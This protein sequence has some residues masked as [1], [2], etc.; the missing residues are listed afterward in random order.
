M[1]IVWTHLNILATKPM[2]VHVEGIAPCAHNPLIQI[3]FKLHSVIGVQVIALSVRYQALSKNAVH[4]SRAQIIAEVWQVQL[5]C[6]VLGNPL[7]Q[8]EWK[9]LQSGMVP[10]V[11]TLE[12]LF[13]SVDAP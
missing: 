2:L 3:L 7:R 9:E 12:C 10:L 8:L 6:H 11:R 13:V 1:L 5:I 4:F